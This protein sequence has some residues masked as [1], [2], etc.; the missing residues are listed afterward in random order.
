MAKTGKGQGM[1]ET[2]QA[3]KIVKR[4]L[5]KL[6][7][8]ERNSRVHPDTQ[9][10]Q[11]KNSILEWGWTVP[12]L[13]DENDNLIAG[14]GRIFAAELIGMKDVPC[15]VAEGW[16][17]E[18]KRAYVIADNKLAEGGSWDNDI[19]YAELNELLDGDFNIEL[20]AVDFGTGDETFAPSVEPTFNGKN[21]TGG[22]VE[23]ASTSQGGHIA[24]LSKD[25][26]AQATEVI[27]P[28]CAES[29]KVQGN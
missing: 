14:H 2:W 19:L 3:K 23:K 9:I 21:V 27:C 11:L 15:I 22:D 25:K 18:Q 8:Y 10:E 26:S 12:V 5:S 17:D 6:V 1:A 13:I 16:T 28:Y 29:F 20:L 24:S 7:P 4:K